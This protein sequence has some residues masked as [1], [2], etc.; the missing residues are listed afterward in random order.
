MTKALDWLLSDDTRNLQNPDG[1]PFECCDCPFA[2]PDPKHDPPNPADRGEGYYI[3][4]LLENHPT[5]WGEGPICDVKD[6]K[7]Q[8]RRELDNR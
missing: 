6:W 2:H 8:A 4:G 7:R 1:T 3:C 5:V